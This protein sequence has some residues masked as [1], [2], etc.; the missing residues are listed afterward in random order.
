MT[1]DEAMGEIDAEELPPLGGYVATSAREAAKT[2]L[3]SDAG[4]PILAKWRYGLGRAAAFTSDT[5]PR[6]AEDWIRWPE[7]AKLWAQIV[8]S[9]AGRDVMKDI[10]VEVAHEE[11]D[12]C[13]RLTADLKDAS[14][15]FVT[16]RVLELMSYDPQAG[17]K[18]VDVKREGPGLFS[19]LVPRGEYGRSHQFAWRLPDAQGESATVPFGYVQ[20]FSP[21]FRTLGVAADTFEQLKSRNLGTVT[22]VGNAVLKLPSKSSTE[23]VRLWPWLLAAA[24]CLVPFD[25]LVRRIG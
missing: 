19:A 2:I 20:S 3:I 16:D 18:A 14:G 24:L 1:D 4:D 12:D 15:N 13:I 21:E 7:F 25:I 22:T 11:R 6:W 17:A 9:V 23:Q 5:K 10:E 8:R